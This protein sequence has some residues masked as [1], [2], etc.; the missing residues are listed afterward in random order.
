MPPFNLLVFEWT[1]SEQVQRSLSP[2]LFSMRTIELRS[3]VIVKVKMIGLGSF[4][5]RYSH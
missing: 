1:L 5:Q 4:E 3:R 2:S